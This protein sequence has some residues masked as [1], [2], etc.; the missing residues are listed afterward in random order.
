MVEPPQSQVREPVAA[1]TD[2][3]ACRVPLAALRCVAPCALRDARRP[4][5]CPQDPPTRSSCSASSLE[6]RPA[7]FRLKLLDAGPAGWRSAMIAVFAPSHEIMLIGTARQA[8]ASAIPRL[9]FVAASISWLRLPLRSAAG[10]STSVAVTPTAS[11]P[12]CRRRWRPHASV[13]LPL[14]KFAQDSLPGCLHP[15]RASAP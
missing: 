5:C 10:G 6:P 15:P 14:C 13:P 9:P 1:S 2:C 12:H 4:C 7:T 3:W 11:A 8:G